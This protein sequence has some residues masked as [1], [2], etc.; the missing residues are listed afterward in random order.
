MTHCLLQS[1]IIHS[2]ITLT[3]VPV[4]CCHRWAGGAARA[5]CCCCCC[6]PRLDD[7]PPAHSCLCHVNEG[8]G[9]ANLGLGGSIRRARCVV[10][11]CL[12]AMSVG[13]FMESLGW[14]TSYPQGP[15]LLCGHASTG[16]QSD[17]QGVGVHQSGCWWLERVLLVVGGS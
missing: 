7:L 13:E 4:S 16:L 10:S 2:C 11:R 6:A 3:V 15:P 17:R 5:H 12:H 8:S 9:F 14:G 1:P